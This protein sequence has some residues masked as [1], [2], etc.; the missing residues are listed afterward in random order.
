[1]IDI[2][3]LSYLNTKVKWHSQSSFL[4]LI[5]K[6]KCLLFLSQTYNLLNVKRSSMYLTVWLKDF[7]KH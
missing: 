1:M 4:K 3:I 6:G 5:Q 2:I 7:A